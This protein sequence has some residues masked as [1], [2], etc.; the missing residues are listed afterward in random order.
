M[1]IDMHYCVYALTR[2]AGLTPEAARII[3]ADLFS[4]FGNSG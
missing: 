1:Q 4:S 2:L 3:V